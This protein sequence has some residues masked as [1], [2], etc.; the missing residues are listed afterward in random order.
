MDMVA[1]KLVLKG[2][3]GNLVNKNALIA[4]Q[5]GIKLMS[6]FAKVLIALMMRF[7]LTQKL[8]VK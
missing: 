5:T 1:E 7:S 3:F 6:T 4:H 2:R 8:M